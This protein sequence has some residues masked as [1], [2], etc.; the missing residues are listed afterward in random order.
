MGTKK[1]H[2]AT[3]RFSFTILIF[4]IYFKA[5]QLLHL[6]FILTALKWRLAYSKTV[7]IAYYIVSTIEIT[8]YTYK[9][10]LLGRLNS[11]CNRKKKLHCIRN[12]TYFNWKWPF[13]DKYCKHP[14]PLVAGR[15]TEVVHLDCDYKYYVYFQHP[16]ERLFKSM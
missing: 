2:C 14:M 15:Q 3:Q 9:L 13:K 11:F 8:S 4:G 1:G 5:D 12:K 7:R 16:H 6:T 10:P